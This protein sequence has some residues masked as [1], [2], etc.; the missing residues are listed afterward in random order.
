MLMPSLMEELLSLLMGVLFSSLG[1]NTKSC[2]EV[3]FQDASRA[4][5]VRRYFKYV[6]KLKPRLYF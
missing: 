5:V 2:N 4:I 1:T 6:E 3:S